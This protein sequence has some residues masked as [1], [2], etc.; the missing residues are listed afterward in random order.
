MVLL[1]AG[2]LAEYLA[3][4]EPDTPIYLRDPS[5]YPDDPPANAVSIE[6]AMYELGA[7]GR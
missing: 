1:T 7:E 5:H 2:E 4:L 3:E 6:V